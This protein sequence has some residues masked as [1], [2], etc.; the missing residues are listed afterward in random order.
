MFK[1]DKCLLSKENLT[2]YAKTEVL[3]ITI[4]ILTFGLTER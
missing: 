3:S 4:K 2:G 1:C